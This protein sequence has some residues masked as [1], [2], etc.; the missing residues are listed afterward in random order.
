[1]RIQFNRKEK[2]REMQTR[3]G[4]VA[5]TLPLYE[6]WRIHTIHSAY[7]KKARRTEELGVV[8]L[9]LATSSL[10]QLADVLGGDRGL[11]IV[12]DEGG[13]SAEEVSTLVFGD[14]EGHRD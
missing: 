6:G 3:K 7:I 8:G 11:V 10:D 4:R 9:N 14:S 2:R 13:V 5:T 1:M 12:E